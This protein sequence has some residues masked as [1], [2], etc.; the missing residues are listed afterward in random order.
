MPLMPTSPVIDPAQTRLLQELK[1]TSPLLGCRFSPDG[2]FVFAGSQDNSVQRWHLDGA[3]KTALVGHKSWIRA[4][5]F[6]AREKL[7]FSGSYDG[8][9]LTWSLE[10]ESPAPTRMIAAHKGFLRALAVSPDGKLLASCGNDHMVRLWNVIDG[11]PVKELA[12]HTS[13]VYNV[14]FHP[15][16]PLLVS[17]DLMGIVKVW[18]VAKGT[19]E[20]ELDAK[21]L[22]KYDNT[23]E[24]DHGGVRSM[25]FS[26]D[27]ALLACAGITDVQNAFAGIGK[28]AV[29]LFD[30]A[31]GKQKFLLRPRENFQGT[32]WGV[33]QFPTGQIAACAGGNGGMLWYWKPDAAADVFAFKLPNNARDLDLHPDGRRLAVAFFDGAVRIY[34]VGPKG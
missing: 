6:A 28:P 34:D 24:A 18:D 3:K 14:A 23:F 27:G 12:G 15:K 30:W 19:V 26:A 13:H 32:M 25:A 5:A 22:H 17:A 4:F 8:K 2:L 11:T 29:V 20:R 1:H 21:V 9:L 7:L 31:S 33:V 10:A 16:Q